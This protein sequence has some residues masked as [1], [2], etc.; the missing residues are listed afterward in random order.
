LFFENG[1]R[2][3]YI[4][5]PFAFPDAT[6]RAIEESP[7][8]IKGAPEPEMILGRDSDKRALYFEA[9]A[10]SFSPS[11]DNSSQARG[12]LLAC[13]PPFAE[14]LKPLNK[15]VLCYVVPKDCCT[16]MS[17]CLTTLANELRSAGFAP[18]QHSTHGLAV[19]G[20][21]LVYSWDHNF[22]LHSGVA[23]DS[24]SVIHE[25]QDDTDPSPLLLVYTDED[26]PDAQ[27]AGYYRR[28]LIN[29]VV[30]KLV[31]DLNLLSPGK[32]YSGSADEILRQ[33]SDGVLEYVGRKRQKSMIR[34]VRQ[35]V[36]ARLS[37]FW[38]GKPYSPVKLEGDRLEIC[39]KDNLAKSEFLDWLED[40][41]RTGFTDQLPPEETPLLPGIEP[42]G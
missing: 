21:D 39:F 1:F 16:L 4:E 8:D 22:K 30:A 6:A 3:V 15:S 40:P 37:S 42:E 41:K 36:L 7:L 5:Q 31:C 13:G 10:N 17:D 12:H 26:C 27:Q 25:L 11:S 38:T 23:T 28:I 24:V 19:S 14:T 20:Q 32:T 33:T 34:I 29:Q 18:G 35:N 2:L 9:K